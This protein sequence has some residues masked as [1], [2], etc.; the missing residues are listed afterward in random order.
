MD[1]DTDYV[2]KGIELIKKEF[3]E[4]HVIESAKGVFS[5]TN[6]PKTDKFHRLVFQSY[7]LPME[8][9]YYSLIKILKEDFSFDKM[10]KIID[11]FAAAE[12]SSFFGVSAQRLGI[13][14]DKVSQYLATIGKM[15]KDMFQIVREL[16]IIDERLSLY[17]KSKKGDESAEVTLKGTWIDL[18]EGGAKNP[19]SVFGMASELG[20]AILPDLFFSINLKSADEVDARIKKMMDNNEFNPSVLRVVARKL[21]SYY[22]WKEH[23]YKELKTRRKFTLRY[24]KQHY[25]TIQLYLSW[26]KPYI[27]TIR[28]LQMNNKLKN[29]VEVVSAFESAIMELEFIAT[30]SDIY[31]K[32]KSGNKKY[33]PVVIVNLTYR[34]R[35]SMSFSQEYQRGPIHV[36]RV[37][38]S[39]RGYVWTNKELEKFLKVRRMEQFELIS[40]YDA[41]IKS[42][43]EALGDDLEKYLEELEQEKKSKNESNEEKKEEEKIKYT[44][45]FVSLFDG[46]KELFSS[47]IPKMPKIDKSKA[48]DWFNNP[49]EIKKLKDKDEKKSASKAVDVAL[50]K[51]YEV[52]K[53]SHRMLAW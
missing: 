34:T 5:E 10:I 25:D 6:Y 38:I 4:A 30:K 40:S 48:F 43:L 15:I 8:E 21:K 14:Q 36:G 41:D 22:T 33:L 51:S 16:R 45:P 35:P 42:T 3:G 7:N 24:L 28:Q 1:F 17:E 44:D 12:G 53:K 47:L 32:V 13:Q 23:T 2:E 49:E 39:L 29:D 27:D 19:A 52:F 50:C 31:Y 26:V 20:F 46:F 37:E 9:P 18:V 11:S